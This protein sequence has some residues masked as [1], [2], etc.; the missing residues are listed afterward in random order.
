MPFSSRLLVGLIV[1]PCALAAQPSTVIIVRHAER[2]AE[3]AGDPSLTEA[4]TQRAKDLA[5]TL[6][7]AKVTSVITTHLQRTQLTARPLMDATGLSPIVVR[8]G[9]AGHAD[10]VAAAVLRRPPGEVVLVVGH[11]NTVPGIIAALGGPRMPD[12]CDGQYSN[13]FILEYGADRT[14]P[15]FIRAKYG[16]ADAADSDA[17]NRSMR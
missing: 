5:A 12:L 15:R 1:L 7:A 14:A 16:A 10:S 17:C 11:S 2:A 9:G 6:G 4:G 3:P 13:L 8:A